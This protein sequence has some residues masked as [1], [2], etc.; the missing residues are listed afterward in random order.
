MSVR[1]ALIHGTYA[2]LLSRGIELARMALMSEGSPGLE[3]IADVFNVNYFG[4]PT[5]CATRFKL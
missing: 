4:K 5:R 2:V 1:L 3:A